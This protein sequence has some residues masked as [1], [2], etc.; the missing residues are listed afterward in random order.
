MRTMLMTLALCAAGITACETKRSQPV[1]QT[2]R[3]EISRQAFLSVYQVLEHPRCMN[4]HPNGDAPLQGDDSHIHTMN[5]KRGIDGHGVYAL[6][7]SNCHQPENAP[8]LHAP[9]GNPKW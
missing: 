7:C 3:E 5:V 4:C 1:K 8:G 2:N 9:P 6:K